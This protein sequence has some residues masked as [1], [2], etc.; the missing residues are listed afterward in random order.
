[1]QGNVWEWCSDV[2]SNHPNANR[3]EKT[4]VSAAPH[5]IIR[6]GSWYDV[7][8][9]CLPASRTKLAPAEQYD[10]VGFR[11]VCDQTANPPR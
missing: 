3:G 6:G 2:P 8:A 7:P 4:S 10:N 5:R 11:V 9:L 1:M